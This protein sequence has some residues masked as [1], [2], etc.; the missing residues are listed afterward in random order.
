[1]YVI[2]KAKMALATFRSG[3][4]NLNI[5]NADTIEDFYEDVLEVF[6]E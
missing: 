1:M 5:L 6:G 2:E 4:Y 3:M